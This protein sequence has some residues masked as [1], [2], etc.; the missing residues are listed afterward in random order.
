M[1]LDWIPRDPNGP[2]RAPRHLKDFQ[3]S[4]FDEMVDSM[5][6]NYEMQG[7][8][9]VTSDLWRTAGAHCREYFE[10]YNSAVLACFSSATMGDREV[11]FYPPLIQIIR[12]QLAK[13]R[14][15]N[16]QP[17]HSPDNL[18]YSLFANNL[19]AGGGRG[20]GS[21]P[22][23]ASSRF[24]FDFGFNQQNQEARESAPAAPRRSHGY[25]QDDF[26][27][28]DLRKLADA[29][30]DCEAVLKMQPH[31]SEK[32]ILELACS[33]IGLPLRRALKLKQSQ[34]QQSKAFAAA[35]D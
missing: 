9:P 15:E 13:I 16:T 8:L 24:S 11:I 22:S 5:F 29:E 1:R 20:G 33:R 12:E 35:G 2:L 3:R 17:I 25:T 30:R 21:S 34:R 18:Q 7:Y 19:P 14:K 31:L 10:K 28:R 4:W 32:D 27:A 23:S 26:D 6:G